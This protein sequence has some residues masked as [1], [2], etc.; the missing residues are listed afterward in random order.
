[1]VE[2]ALDLDRVFKSLADPTRRDILKRVCDH[3]QRISEL[4]ER[5]KMSFAGVAKHLAVLE[6][7]GLVAK[8]RRGNEQIVDA[9]KQAFAF[10]MEHLQQYQQI[11]DARFDRLENII[12]EEK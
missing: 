8:E 9:N 3:P 10:A 5:Y 2:Y 1:M 4:A 11:W 7:A 12:R 6:K